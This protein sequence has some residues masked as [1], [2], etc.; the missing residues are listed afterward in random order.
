ML[1]LVDYSSSDE[2]EKTTSIAKRPVGEENKEDEN[3]SKKQKIEPKVAQKP[4]LPP[5]P[6]D[7]DETTPMEQTKTNNG[8][9]TESDQGI[10]RS[11][12]PP[13]LCNLPKPNRAKNNDGLQYSQLFE[14]CI[15]LKNASKTYTWALKLIFKIA[16]FLRSA[17]FSS[18]PRRSV[19]LTLSTTGEP[20]LPSHSILDLRTTRAPTVSVMQLSTLL[21]FSFV[22]LSITLVHTDT[23]AVQAVHQEC[24]TN[25]SSADTNCCGCC[26][27]NSQCSGNLISKR[28][29]PM[30][31]SFCGCMTNRAACYGSVF[32]QSNPVNGSDSFGA[33]FDPS[34]ANCRFTSSS[35]KWIVC[36]KDHQICESSSFF[37]CC[38]PDTYCTSTTY[39]SSYPVC[40]PKLPTTCPSFLLPCGQDCYSPDTYC[41][42][43]NRLTQLSLCSVQLDDACLSQCKGQGC[44]ATSIGTLCYNPSRYECSTDD[45][46]NNQI[47]PMGSKGCGS[48]CYFPSQYTCMKGVLTPL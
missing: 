42:Q 26:D 27:S 12:L 13:Q 19:R 9:S 2:E 11:L 43:D 7:F 37:D 22:F 18:T 1:G 33:C 31:S 15:P 46:G 21:L 28:C 10:S 23:S 8:R 35:N 3:A 44:C 39:N 41:C 34:M 48:A 38:P 36:P 17:F 16:F 32:G 45:T 6:D 4:S 20:S 5:L 40:A 24:C 30:G 47:C 14:C 25:C 29:C